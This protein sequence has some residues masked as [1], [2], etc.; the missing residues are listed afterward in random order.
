MSRPLC[1]VALLLAAGLG[2]LAGCSGEAPSAAGRP[3]ADAA[4]EGGDAATDRGGADAGA[5]DRLGPGAAGT[6]A[7]PGQGADAQAE[8]VKDRPLRTQR[9][10]AT[11]GEGRV[12]FEIPRAGEVSDD[13]F[14]LPFP[15]DLRVRDGRV[16]LGELPRP[17]ATPLAPDLVERTLGAIEA[18]RIGFSLHPTVFFRLSRAPG[19]GEAARAAL[20]RAVTFVDVTPGARERGQ[21]VPFS[22]AV[23]PVGRYLCG[24]GLAVSARGP[25]PLL[26]GH[27]YAVL[28]RGL[29]DA[30]GDPLGADADLAVVLAAKPVS[31]DERGAAWQRYA[32]LRAWLAEQGIA[33]GALAGATLFTTQV[34]DTLAELRRAVGATTAPALRELVRCGEGRTST[35][36]DP[37]VPACAGLARDARFAEYR[38]R[39]EIPVFQQGTPPFEDQGGGIALGPDG[40]A[41]PVRREA[42]CV[43]LTVPRGQAPAGGWPLVVYAHGTGG[44][45][46][47]HVETG[48]AGELAAGE[49]GGGAAAPMATLGYDGVLHGSRK[50]IS[51]RTTEELVYNV[52][53]PTAARDNSLQ[54]AADLF[55]IAR[56]LDAV[57]A[58]APVAGTR[59]GLYGHS[60]GGNAAALAAGYEPRFGVVVLSGTGG[61]LAVSMLEKRKPFPVGALLPVLLGESIAVDA[62]HPVLSLVQMYFDRA[63]PL[64]HARR[65]VMAPA[66]DVPP[67]HLLHVYG[68]DDSYAPEVTQG[69]FG[70]AA[71]LPVL[72]PL[73]AAGGATDAQPVPVVEA[74]VASNVVAGALRV[75]AVQAQYRPA[76]YD[77]HFV[78]TQHPA[79]RAAVRRMLGTYFRDGTPEV[80]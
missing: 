2:A 78:S 62:G 48:L 59:V 32:P 76:G 64:N 24:P 19:G 63:D 50:G 57:A 80:R 67:R 27:S 44:D 43:S 14:R 65:I 17:G 45:F 9:G 35:C 55:A 69:A 66:G 37:R 60:Q 36:D 40:R 75:T 39:L 74:P 20:A 6:D 77:G 28:V 73:W 54:A 30:Q 15:N 70:A 7:V 61:G 13:F 26:P 42:I 51:P 58:A 22:V 52:F 71:G 25:A 29:V 23:P 34:V 1:R 72:N 11:A 79:A 5:V 16:D 31:G 49:L 12:L 33:P 18:E 46:R 53:N 10:C 47:N 3:A 21:P 68:A 56:A 4:G 38:G 41:A 8:A